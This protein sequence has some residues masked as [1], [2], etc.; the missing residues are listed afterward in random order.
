[1]YVIGLTLWTDMARYSLFVVK[2]HALKHVPTN[3]T[4]PVRFGLKRTICTV[5]IRG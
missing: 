4:V 1:M 5:T 2:V 3:R